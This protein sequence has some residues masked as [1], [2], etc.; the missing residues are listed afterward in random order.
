M[1]EFRAVGPKHNAI[2]EGKVY[3]L[4][5][6]GDGYDFRDDDGYERWVRLDRNIHCERFDPVRPH[7]PVRTVTRREVVPGTYGSLA[8]GAVIN[9]P[10]RV[11]IDLSLYASLAADEIDTLVQH[12]TA[13][14][15][16]LRAQ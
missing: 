4:T 8:V 11:A 6:S 14:A 12:L 13:I 3:D 1:T 2:T 15:E 9:T 5:E 7:G 16:V 10:D